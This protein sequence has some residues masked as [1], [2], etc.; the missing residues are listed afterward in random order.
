MLME[1]LVAHF[2]TLVQ[3]LQHTGALLGQIPKIEQIRKLI[4]F[5]SKTQHTHQYG[6]RG[7]CEREKIKRSR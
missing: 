1:K 2:D 5:F 3:R 7:A 6:A 4:T